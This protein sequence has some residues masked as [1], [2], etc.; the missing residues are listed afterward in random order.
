MLQPTLSPS[1]APH[2]KTAR[3][4]QGL[5]DLQIDAGP[6]PFPFTSPPG[7][8]AATGQFHLD[9]THHGTRPITMG[10][11]EPSSHSG[12]SIAMDSDLKICQNQTVLNGANC[13]I[14]KQA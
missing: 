10:A 9:G 13:R 5:L 12:L 14:A 3:Q 11:R 6:F 2:S 4:P 8:S 7:D 1:L